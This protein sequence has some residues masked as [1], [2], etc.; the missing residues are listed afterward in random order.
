MSGLRANKGFVENRAYKKRFRH[1]KIR[2]HHKT[3]FA[4]IFAIILI[5]VALSSSLAYSSLSSQINARENLAD[6]YGATANHVV[7]NEVYYDTVSG[8]DSGT[9]AEWV[10]IYNPT[11]TR[12]D[13]SGWRITD[14]PSF[15]ASGEGYWEFPDNTFI[16]PGEY[17]VVTG[18]VVEFQKD[19]PS[20]TPD[21]DTVSGGSVPDVIKGGSFGLANTGDDVHLFDSSRNEVDAMWYGSGGDMGSNNAAPDVHP[22]HSL[23]RYYNAEDTDNPSH[24]FYDESSPTPR[25]QNT[26]SIPELNAFF[27]FVVAAGI[28]VIV[29]LRNKK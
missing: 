4:L 17:I 8:K 29:K 28:A 12:V 26:Q 3:R 16:D 6:N 23:A 2:V 5:V 27:I 9:G 24:D 11:E 21:F 1:Y 7:I 13:I 25:A 20:V 10:E 22:G 15:D 18:D 19:F 14:D